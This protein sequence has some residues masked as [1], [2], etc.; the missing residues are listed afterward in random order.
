MKFWI[1]LWIYGTEEGP[2]KWPNR[3]PY[4]SRFFI[5]DV[6]R[7]KGTNAEN[8]ANLFL[9]SIDSFGVALSSKKKQ[10]NQKN[11]LSI[12]YTYKIAY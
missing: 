2:H 4:F 1:N 12:I 3:L 6:P 8:I 11:I 10:K 7:E 9:V 5:C